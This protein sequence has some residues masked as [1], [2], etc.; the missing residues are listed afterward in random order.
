MDIN[1]KEISIPC[2]I[3]GLRLNPTEGGYG[4]DPLGISFHRV[5]WLLAICPSH[6][7]FIA[8]TAKVSDMEG[9]KLR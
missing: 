3:C 1:N 4:E 8:T 6:G 2:P 5:F 7:I 9:V